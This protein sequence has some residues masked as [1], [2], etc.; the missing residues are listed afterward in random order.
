MTPLGR[1]LED[2]PEAKP[3]GRRMR[4]AFTAFASTGAPRS[5]LLPSWPPYGAADPTTLLFSGV[6]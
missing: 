2:A 6:E 4:D 5:P 3:V 1:F